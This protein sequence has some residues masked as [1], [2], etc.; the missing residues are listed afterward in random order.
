M[1]LSFWLLIIVIYIPF[2][3]AHLDFGIDKEVGDYTVDFGY[4][5][6]KIMEDKATLL[7]FT[8]IDKE[9]RNLIQVDR[10]WVRF[11]EANNVIFTANLNPD[12]D[13]GLITFTF[14]TAGEYNVTARFFQDERELAETS[15]TLSVE[16][17][18]LGYVILILF[19]LILS[20]LILQQ[21]KRLERK[22]KRN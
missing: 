6:E 11:S 8:L 3:M 15:F 22:S 17:D 16:D 21:K 5:S 14:P 19:V 7:A 4:S 18:W 2:S 1:R 12:L 9:S 10:I 20:I 13:Q